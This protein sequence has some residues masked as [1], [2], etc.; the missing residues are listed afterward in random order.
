MIPN[1]VVVP[2]PMRVGFGFLPAFY[3]KT[4]TT[5]S[6]ITFI[7]GKR[8]LDFSSCSSLRR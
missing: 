5:V 6:Q 1:T 7:E 4:V 8:K 3:R 2:M